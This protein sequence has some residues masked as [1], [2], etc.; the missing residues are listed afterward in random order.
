[1]KAF[2][3]SADIENVEA[4]AEIIRNILCCVPSDSRAQ[5]LALATKREEAECKEREKG[6][7]WVRASDISMDTPG[8][9]HLNAITRLQSLIVQIFVRDIAN[10][11]NK[12]NAAAILFAEHPHGTGSGLLKDYLPPY[13][14]VNVSV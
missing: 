4:W 13:R 6:P 12:Q 8:L 14:A 11:H 9:R 3:T 5:V 7:C 2:E 10:N 1:M